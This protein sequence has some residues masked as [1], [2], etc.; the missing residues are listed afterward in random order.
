MASCRMNALNSTYGDASGATGNWLDG[1][2]SAADLLRFQELMK[3]PLLFAPG[4]QYC[5]CNTNFNLAGY[6]V[7]RVSGAASFLVDCYHCI[8]ELLACGV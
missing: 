1:T 6:V 2:A 4:S 3:A 7:E 8:L 5:Y